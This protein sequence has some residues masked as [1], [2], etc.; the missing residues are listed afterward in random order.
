MRR[1]LG[2][3]ALIAGA[4][5]AVAGSFLPLYR[6][7]VDFSGERTEFELTSWG[8]R[9]TPGGVDF[10]DGVGTVFFGV[11]I[12]VAAVLLVAS[13][14]LVSV[15]A[16]V[17]ARIALVARATAVGAPMLLV[18]AV[19]SVGQFVVAMVRS[20]SA[21]YP[22]VHFSVGTGMWTLVAACVVAFVG[23]LLVQEWP[24]RAPQPE[25]PLV[26]RVLDDD[27]DTPPMGIPHH[28]TG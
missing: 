22:F 2:V 9:L 6:Q 14:V 23:G 13:A 11:P 27:T 12:A 21:A 18:G 24:E 15:A 20:P 8:S 10:R 19:W 1:G 7:V 5:Q 17:S 26:Y 28:P 16:R 4:V 3:F 25:G